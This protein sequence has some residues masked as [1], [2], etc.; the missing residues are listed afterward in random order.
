MRSSDRLSWVLLV[1]SVFTL[2]ACSL[3]SEGVS[4]QL[5]SQSDAPAPAGASCTASVDCGEGQLCVDGGCR[6]ARTS[7]AAEV[8]ASAGHAQR[9]AGDVDG[10]LSSYEQAIE[11]YRRAQVPVPPEV[12][13]G[14]ANHD[15]R[16]PCVLEHLHCLVRRVYI[17]VR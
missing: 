1:A 16:R 10:A 6:Y 11:S 2:S 7:V 12:L 9:E 17:S 14:A 4:A 13:C 3:G 8:L 5:E 15:P